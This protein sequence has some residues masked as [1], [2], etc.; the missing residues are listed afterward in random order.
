MQ[1]IH[2]ECWWYGGYCVRTLWLN[3]W[4]RKKETKE[5]KHLCADVHGKEHTAFS[6]CTAVT[7]A[8]GIMVMTLF[9]V[10]VIF[11]D[12]I[13]FLYQL[14]WINS[15]FYLIK[16]G[17]GEEGETIWA[18]ERNG[19]RA[20]TYTI[21][22]F[23]FVHFMWMGVFVAFYLTLNFLIPNYCY[24]FGRHCSVNGVR[25]SSLAFFYLVH[26]FVFFLSF[27]RLLFLVLVA[28]NSPMWWFVRT[29]RHS[30]IVRYT[31]RMN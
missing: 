28:Y 6:H 10:V 14:H 3:Q 8:M 12:E 1:S 4:N 19:S 13:S 29:S 27:G 11:A 2:F 25:I 17:S 16:Y 24:C 5:Q 31:F 22:Y 23:H 7:T 30:P 18:G 15:D 9:V 20:K 26:F 21:G